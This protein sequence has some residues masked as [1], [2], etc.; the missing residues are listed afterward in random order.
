MSVVGE[1]AYGFKLIVLPGVALVPAPGV[2]KLVPDLRCQPGASKGAAVGA[3]WDV[4]GG[5]CAPA[6]S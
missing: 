3:A 2:E 1:P 5:G 4:A 6:V